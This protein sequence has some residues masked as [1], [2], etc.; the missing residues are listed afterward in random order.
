[1]RPTQK[2]RRKETDAKK[3]TQRNRRKETDAKK[4]TEENRKRID[5]G[6]PDRSLMTRTLFDPGKR[7]SGGGT[8]IADSISHYKEK[9]RS[10]ITQPSVG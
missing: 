8:I 2:N 7:F 1:L 3:P 6:C 5:I 4:P 9:N 10:K